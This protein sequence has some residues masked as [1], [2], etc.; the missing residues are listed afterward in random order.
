MQI[1]N[2]SNQN[3]YGINIRPSIILNK[4]KTR[5]EKY[6]KLICGKVSTQTGISESELLS[7]TAGADRTKLDFLRKLAS[8]FKIRNAR[9]IKDNPEHILNIYSLVSNPS[10][11]HFN[12]LSQSADS[13]EALEK[14]FSLADNKESLE[15]VEKLQYD[16][17]DKSENKSKTIINL[18]SSKN[19]DRYIGNLR[20]IS[21]Y[22]K[23]NAADENAIEK[24]DELVDSG[25]YNRLKYDIQW[26]VKKLFKNK[27]IKDA[28][29]TELENP[30]YV[31]SQKTNDKTKS[32]RICAYSKS[33]GFFSKTVKILEN[34][35]NK[36]IYNHFM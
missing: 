5:D 2:I 25:K 30:F 6:M 22:L 13:F 8:K 15:F 27:R 32:Y 35:I 20:S 17:L 34:K 11:K 36:F 4:S 16:V 26:A 29:I 24:L 1:N 33:E 19:R 18:L 28:S 31:S 12:I 9:T 7:H 21:S 23:L 14:I 3:F 10:P